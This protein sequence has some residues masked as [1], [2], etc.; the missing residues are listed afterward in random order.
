MSP[1]LSTFTHHRKIHF[2][3]LSPCQHLRSCLFSS[4][5]L[6]KIVSPFLISPI[7]TRHGQS[8]TVLKC[9]KIHPWL[10]QVSQLM[11]PLSYHHWNVRWVLKSGTVSH[12]DQ[13][14]SAHEKYTQCTQ[15]S[16]MFFMC[17]N[18]V[19]H[20]SQQSLTVTGLHI[21]LIS[22][23]NARVKL[24]PITIK[25]IV[26]IPY[27]YHCAVF[28]DEVT[29]TLLAC[30][31]FPLESSLLQQQMPATETNLTCTESFTL[32]GICFSKL[33]YLNCLFKNTVP[34]S[35]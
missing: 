29:V 4:S 11:Q 31:L 20:V 5:F 28:L 18:Y 17:N 25:C 10:L 12:I 1:T 23:F 22:L 26:I 14:V 21:K 13:T 2:N 24:I 3:V 8:Y 30:Q 35:N 16:M 33:L 15:R 7:Y 9:G 6:T 34:K 27:L 32:A 19:K